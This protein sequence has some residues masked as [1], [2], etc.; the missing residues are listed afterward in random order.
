[1]KQLLSYI[2]FRKFSRKNK[3]LFCVNLCIGI[4]ILIL[5]F[6][7]EHSKWGEDTLNTA[8][9]CFIAIESKKAAEKAKNI[10]ESKDDKLYEQIAFIDI[11][12]N[13]YKKWKR[14]LIT[15]RDEL[16]KI[17]E[18]A[19]LS[20][21]KAIVLDILFE[22]ND[23]CN[24]KKDKDLK[25]VFRDMTNK[26]ATTKVIFPVRITCDGNIRKNIFD[27]L[28]ERNPNFYTAI[29]NISATSTDRII[30]YW[31]PYEIV[32]N[33]KILW[34]VSVLA[35][36]IA[37]EKIEELKTIENKIKP[38]QLAENEDDSITMNNGKNIYLSAKKADL[39]RHRIRFLLV[40]PNIMSDHWGGN[41]KEVYTVDQAKHVNFKDKIVIIGNSSPDMGDIS[42]TPVGN[43][44]GMY[45]IGN[46]ANTILLGMQPSHL[47]WVSI[48]MDIFL[49]IVSA[50]LFVYFASL[51]AQILGSIILIFI[52]GVIS[53]HYF[54]LTGTF[55]NFTFAVA[56]MFFHNII[57][58]IEEI[59]EN[60]FLKHS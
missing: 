14:P 37:N 41:I 13:T 22:E 5:C 11:N 49:I 52:F 31:I 48:V 32:N 46:A 21:A 24:P 3:I 38:Q 53:Y 42:P 58:D 8:F 33:S 51:L 47:L 4:I 56:G 45:I 30:R 16:A 6:I 20:N 28:I 17:V 26:A 60:R 43:M 10:H 15:P 54:L 39:Y 1:M 35:A 44:A 55:L 57:S 2:D 12:D 19:Y 27:E 34:N 59:I 7:F 9:D 29:P 40:P 25:K 50:Y 18:G 23:C 36:V